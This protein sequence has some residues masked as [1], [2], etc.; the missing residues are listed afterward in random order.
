MSD[1]AA[2]SGPDL[3]QGVELSD[4][5]KGGSLLGHVGDEAVLL[6]RPGGGDG[7]FAVGATCTH[8]GGPLAE[9][10]VEGTRVRCPWHHACFDVTTGE[11]VAAPALNALACYAVERRGTRVVVGAKH[12]AAPK[13]APSKAP[14]SVVIVGAGAAGNA[15]AEMLRREGYAGPVTMV[16]AERARP[17]DR[18]NLS[19]DY[20]AGTAQEDWV[21]LRGDDFYAEQKID[22]VS[23]VH[24]TAIDVAGR[25]VQLSDGSSRTFGALLVATGAEPVRLQ[26]PGADKPHVHT[27]RSLDDSKAIIAAATSGAKRAVVVGASFIGLEVAA[28]LRTRGLDVHVV[29]PDARPL[30]RVLGPELGDFVRGL[31]DEHGVTFH[32]GRKPAS[33]DDEHVV[34]DDGSRLAADLVVLGVGV[35]PRLEL[36][37]KAGLAVDRGVLVNEYL[38]TSAPG[39]YAAGDLA[40]YPDLRSGERVRIEHWVVAE[41]QGQ[42]AARNMLGHREAYRAAPFFWSQHYDV[43]IAY[44]G[45]AESWDR[46]EV[47]GSLADKNGLV[48]YRRGGKIL[49]L[50]SVFRDKESL[51]AEVLFERGDDAGLERLLASA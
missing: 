50:A 28:S 7:V 22:L 33:F 9:G 20:L 16:G 13:R 42:T 17:V 45:H 31:H 3:T 36:A 35:R 48:A 30:E 11:A 15:A 1:A 10:L 26:L 27:L 6:V 37:E 49:A 14:E 5:P 25:R 47:R 2:P 32:L 34:L 29:A 44:V 43:T 21:Y 51:E 8:Y 18:P 24:A 40:R 19:K 41:R 39:V 46:T 38:E 12:D 23:G 4:I